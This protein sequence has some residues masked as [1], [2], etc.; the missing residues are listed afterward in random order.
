[1]Q[2]SKESKS[3]E[4][5]WIL[6]SSGVSLRPR[7][8]NWETYEKIVRRNEPCLEKCYMVTCLV[9]LEE[10]FPRDEGVV[11]ETEWGPFSE[12]TQFMFP[13]GVLHQEK[14]IRRNAC[15]QG[16]L[17]FMHLGALFRLNFSCAL[18]PMVLS[19]FASIEESAIL[20]HFI[21]VVSS[22]R[23]CLRG[24]RSLSLKWSCLCFCLAFDH[25]F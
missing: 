6:K 2:A 23:P 16:E 4:D 12:S 17:A 8:N 25:L 11:S 10:V 15:V 22:R 13:G 21:S 19:P 14:T 9:E 1:V 20:E 7:F 18:L 3:A 5:S 24:L